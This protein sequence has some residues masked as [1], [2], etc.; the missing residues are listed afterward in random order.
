MS[1]PIDYRALFDD[2]STDAFRAL[3]RELERMLAPRTAPS[4]YRESLRTRLMDAARDEDFY[5]RGFSRRLVFA[6]AVVTGV[7]LMVV[8]YIA[9]RQQAAARATLPAV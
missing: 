5:A 6:M 4:G 2:D 1:R 7:L 8:T 9:W 3:K